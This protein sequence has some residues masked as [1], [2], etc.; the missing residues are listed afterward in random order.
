M[1][2]GSPVFNS[3]LRT[4]NG[5]SLMPLT[6]CSHPPLPD[7]FVHIRE[8]LHRQTTW[9]PKIKVSITRRPLRRKTRLRLH[10]FPPIFV[11]IRQ[12]RARKSGIPYSPFKASPQ[13]P[14]IC[15]NS[16]LSLSEP[17]PKK[18]LLSCCTRPLQWKR[19]GCG[20]LLSRLPVTTSSRRR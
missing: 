10:P 14:S 15:S 2:V 7:R 4:S 11:A 5:L 1:A 9:P 18:E 19:R 6:T 3:H 16:F 12:A 8:P 13:Q 17:T 20:A